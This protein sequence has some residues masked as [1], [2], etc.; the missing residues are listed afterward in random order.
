VKI[1][2]ERE[3][4]VEVG[5]AVSRVVSS[6]SALP[7]LSGI[8]ITA[9]EGEVVFDA[10]DLE[11]FVSVRS[12]FGIDEPGSVVVPGRLFGD[13]LRSLPSGRVGIEGREAE[14]RVWVRGGQS[15]FSVTA[16]PVAD[17]PAIPDMPAGEAARVESQELARAL[18]QTVRAASTDEGRPVLTGVLWSVDA[19][20]LRLAAT[21]SYRLAV[22]ELPVKEGPS[23]AE[24]VI[25]GRALAEFARHVGGEEKEARIWLGET[26]GGFE[27][28]RTRMITRLIEGRFPDYKQLIP[29]AYPN[30][31]VA[32]REQLRQAVERMG[33]V[34]KANTPVKVHLGDDV[35]LTAT[36]TGVADASE[37]VGGVTYEGEPM[38][39]GFN[40]RFLTDGLEDLESERAVIELID[41][42]RPALLKGE[43]HEEH[44]YLLMPVRLWT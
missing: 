21:D 8:R 41:P 16:L 42:G 38:V 1:H 3:A 25:P 36:Q 10:T 9:G 39:V 22:R 35:R 12:D 28:G 20:M 2:G 37:I 44:M 13:I 18:K 17:F 31:L 24:A 26:Q 5:Q 30:K 19:G 33:L 4:L 11:L 32:D 43:G 15:E 29:S 6:R 7:V 23:T 34:A 27:T 40:P 14:G